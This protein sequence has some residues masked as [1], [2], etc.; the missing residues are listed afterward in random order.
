MALPRSVNHRSLTTLRE[1]PVKIGA[2]VLTHAPYVMSQM[3]EVAIPRRLFMAILGQVS[4]LAPL[5][6][7]PT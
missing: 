2:R 1:R 6:L 7:V 4:R 5:T 3:A